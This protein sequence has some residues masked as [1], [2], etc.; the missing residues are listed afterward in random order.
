MRQNNFVF[1]KWSCGELFQL[2]CGTY[3]NSFGF[4]QLLCGTYANGF[5]SF[6]RFVFMQY[7]I[8]MALFGRILFFS[9]VF[10]F[11]LQTT[12]PRR[13]STTLERGGRRAEAWPPAPAG[14]RP[15]ANVLVCHDTYSLPTTATRSEA[16][17]IPALP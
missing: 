9:D 6:M 8:K 17:M 7:V 11:V 1:K 12:P 4:F 14:P 3:A 16:A 5:G 15:A 2:L 13:F 10:F